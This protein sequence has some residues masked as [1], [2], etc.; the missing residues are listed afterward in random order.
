MATYPLPSSI[1]AGMSND[2]RADTLRTPCRVVVHPLP[3]LSPPVRATTACGV[4]RIPE[5]VQLPTYDEAIQGADEEPPTYD[6]A[7]QGTG[8]EP[9]AVPVLGV[10]AKARRK[11]KALWRRAT[12][13]RDA[14]R[15]GP[16]IPM[17]EDRAI[18][19]NRPSATAD[20]DARQTS[21]V[22][23]AA[24]SYSDYVRQPEFEEEVA[25]RLQEVREAE[26]QETARIHNDHARL[27]SRIDAMLQRPN[28][29]ESPCL[30]RNCPACCRIPSGDTNWMSLYTEDHRPTLQM[31]QEY[32]RWC[33]GIMRRAVA[34]E[35]AVVD[36][37]AEL[38]LYDVRRIGRSGAR[39]RA[40]RG[41][42]VCHEP[43]PCLHARHWTTKPRYFADLRDTRALHERNRENLA[44]ARLNIRE[45]FI[46]DAMVEARFRDNTNLE[47]YRKDEYVH[48]WDRMK[49]P[50]CNGVVRV[51]AK[52]FG[53]NG[54]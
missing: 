23:G 31:E 53:Y 54:Y 51:V 40:F 9:L 52:N 44:C 13:R 11:V 15:A 26:I 38:L 7:F 10:W 34:F 41:Q 35:A 8:E 16:V 29:S 12:T 1:A 25:T 43:G 32:L 18:P 37:H 42:C 46:I 39:M 28:I 36:Y 24:L 17:Q 47:V 14:P 20:V 33:V 30:V 4:A 27:Q 48:L 3:P 45:H 19:V 6:E 50:S 22:D 21:V 5:P 49:H 2:A